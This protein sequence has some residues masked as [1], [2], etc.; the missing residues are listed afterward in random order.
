MAYPIQPKPVADYLD[1]YIVGTPNISLE[2]YVTSINGNVGSVRDNYYCALEPGLCSITLRDH[3]TLLDADVL[4]PGAQI[5]VMLG[6]TTVF[7]GAVRDVTTNYVFD[8]DKAR[9]LPETQ[10]SVADAVAQAGNITLDEKAMISQAGM[11]QTLSQFRDKFLYRTGMNITGWSGI[12]TTV[13]QFNQGGNALDI[14]SMAA[15]GANHYLYGGNDTIAA[16]AITAPTSYPYLI[17]DG[18]HTSTG[19]ASVIMSPIDIDH[20]YS[21]DAVVSSVTINNVGFVKPLRSLDDVTDDLNTTYTKTQTLNVQQSFSLDTAAATPVIGWNYLSNSWSRPE[22]PYLG[23]DGSQFFD[24]NIAYDHY[25]S[26][27]S[28]IRLRPK[29]AIPAGSTFVMFDWTENPD[30]VVNPAAGPNGSQWYFRFYAI[31]RTEATLEPFRAAAFI[32]WVDENGQGYDTTFG[33]SI[34]VDDYWHWKQVAVQGTAPSYAHSMV[35]GFVSTAGP[36]IYDGMYIT[37]AALTQ[38][39]GFQTYDGDTPDTTDRIYNWTGSRWGSTSQK[40]ENTLNTLASSILARNTPRELT[41]TFTLNAFESLD[42]VK[43]MITRTQTQADNSGMTV[44]VNGTNKNYRPVGY[45][46]DI[47]PEHLEVTFNVVDV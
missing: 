26:T 29:E 22:I 11:T 13:N 24:L 8:Q 46:F 25:R 37:D 19:G 31:P 36:D 2:A 1:V 7:Y 10:V 27:G 5:K 6:T 35:V 23:A 42:D 21:S 41:K 45:S 18:T 32:V 4:T 39:Y 16:K 28:S 47:Q 40:V 3:K 34:V 9:L 17:T 20:G 14:L 30:M 15:R 38:E 43:T 12:T 44:C 33:S